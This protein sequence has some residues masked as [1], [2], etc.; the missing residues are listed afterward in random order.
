MKNMSSV[1][2]RK[3]RTRS[4]LKTLIISTFLFSAFGWAIS[5]AVDVVG[6]DIVPQ[7]AAFSGSNNSQVWFSTGLTSTG[8][9]SYT[10]YINKDNDSDTIGNYLRGYY[11]D[12]QFGFFKL[13]WS[14]DTTKNVRIV[15]STDKCSSGYGYKFSGFASGSTVGFMQFD[16]SN[17]IY[18][19]YCEADKKLHGYAYSEHIGF[20]SF[21]GLSFEIASLAQNLQTLTSGDDP[22]FVNNN[23]LIL[24]NLPTNSSP[25]TTQNT[26]Q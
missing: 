26:I 25:E 18:V 2:E 15:S 6:M 11:Y 20:Q 1:F 8:A 3:F 17:D 7:E 19:Y 23:S 5:Y 9:T 21:E 12:T 16:Y 24:M 13:D 14:A 22:F 4:L 10:S